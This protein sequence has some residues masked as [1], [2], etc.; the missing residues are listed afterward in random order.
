[1]CLC[2]CVSVCLCVCVSVCLCVCVSVCLC[3]CVS[4][5]LCVC[6]SVCLCVCIGEDEWLCSQ[7]LHVS[8]QSIPLRRFHQTSSS[9]QQA[10]GHFVSPC[11]VAFSNAAR[12]LMMENPVTILLSSPPAQQCLLCIVVFHPSETSTLLHL[13][14]ANIVYSI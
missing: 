12:E 8:I 11:L 13:D 6:V 1:M 9:K 14:F 4:V 10:D 5:C 3:V 7:H 2:V